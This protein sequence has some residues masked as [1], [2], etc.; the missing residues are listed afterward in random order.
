[1]SR[2][3]GGP[4]REGRSQPVFRKKNWAATTREDSQVSP[5]R[6]HLPTIRRGKS[7]EPSFTD[8]KVVQPRKASLVSGRCSLLYR[9][10]LLFKISDTRAKPLSPAF[11]R[12]RQAS[13][14]TTAALVEAEHIQGVTSKNV[15]LETRKVARI[16]SPPP[17]NPNQ[18]LA[19]QQ[20]M[21]SVNE[22]QTDIPVIFHSHCSRDG[23]KSPVWI[24]G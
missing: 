2:G 7:I 11:G 9:E 6:A 24:T 21:R 14:D 12:H 19:A 1:M 22:A 16:T 17:T 20:L 4:R 5:S 8:V 18:A 23:L 10:V 3:F 13:V 15:N